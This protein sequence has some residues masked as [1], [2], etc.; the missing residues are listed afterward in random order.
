[1]GNLLQFIQLLK[2]ILEVNLHMKKGK[3]IFFCMKTYI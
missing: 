1:M 2:L 3:G